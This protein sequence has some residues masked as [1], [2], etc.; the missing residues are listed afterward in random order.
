MKKTT[1]DSKHSSM[2]CEICKRETNQLN[3]IKEDPRKVCQKCLEGL[4]KE[5]NI[6]ES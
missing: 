4:M 3:K 2:I 5:Y 1:Q 6:K